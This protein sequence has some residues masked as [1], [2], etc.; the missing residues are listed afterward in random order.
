VGND[1]ARRRRAADDISLDQRARAV[2]VAELRDLD[3]LVPV[4]RDDR[5]T[6]RLRGV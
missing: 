2:V 6:Q 1:D 4:S 3:V 5:D